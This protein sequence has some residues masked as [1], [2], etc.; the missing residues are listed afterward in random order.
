MQTTRPYHVQVVTPQGRS[1]YITLADGSCSAVADAMQHYPGARRISAKP[2][3]T[4]SAG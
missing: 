3:R 1:A 2:V 4:R